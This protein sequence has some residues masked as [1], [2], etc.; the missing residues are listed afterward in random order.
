MCVGSQ[1]IMKKSTPPYLKHANHKTEIWRTHHANG[2]LYQ[3][4]DCNVFA[5]WLSKE[6][7]ELAEQAGLVTSNVPRTWANQRKSKT[8]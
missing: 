1:E 4:V 6:E 5:G 7:V 2:L 8:A 3:C